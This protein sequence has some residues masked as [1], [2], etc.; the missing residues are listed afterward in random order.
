[1]IK[2]CSEANITQRHKNNVAD[3]V[4]DNSSVNSN[5]FLESFPV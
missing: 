2:P 1:M 5:P 4:A 3:P